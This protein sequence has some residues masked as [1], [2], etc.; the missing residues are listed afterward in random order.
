MATAQD[1]SGERPLDAVKM[2]VYSSYTLPLRRDGLASTLVWVDRTVKIFRRAVLNKNHH[3]SLA[4]YR[5]QFI[6]AH[7][8]FKHCM[9]KARE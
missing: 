1:I 7:C 3:A 4:E 5:R 2:G 6:H 8:D 9:K